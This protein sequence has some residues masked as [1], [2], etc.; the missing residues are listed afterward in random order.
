[1]SIF[2]YYF[3]VLCQIN[4]RVIRMK[5]I[6]ETYNS[7]I[8]ILEST[9]KNLVKDMY[10]KKGN[11]NYKNYIKKYDMLLEGHYDNLNSVKNV[12]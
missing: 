8:R 4:T 11:T 9:R 6:E 5:E 7:F 2:L 10:S 3:V 1:M 12:K